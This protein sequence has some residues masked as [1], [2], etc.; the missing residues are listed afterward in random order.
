M[1]CPFCGKEMEKGFIPTAA[2]S[3]V[4]L[5]ESAFPFQLLL[6]TDKVK[7][8]NGIV[9]KGFQLSMRKRKI[10]A[11]ICRECKKGVFS[12]DQDATMLI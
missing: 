12:F 2:Y 3:C 8:L 9:V 6:D 4:W 10:D 11:E 5:P 7:S 1:K